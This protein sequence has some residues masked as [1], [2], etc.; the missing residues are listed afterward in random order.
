MLTI[1]E[2]NREFFEKS[3]KW[4]ANPEIKK[5]TLSSDI[6]DVNREKW[7]LSLKDEDDYLIWGLKYND[8]P[9]GTFGIKNIEWNKGIGEYW[10]YIGEKD[11]IGKGYGKEMVSFMFSNAKSLHLNKLYLKVADYNER[12]IRLYIKCGF[13]EVDRLQR[14]D[15]QIIIMEKE[16]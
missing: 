9:I 1:T 16:I 3:K 6:D 15:Y 10:G 7:F 5:L 2:F 4:L 8:M 13:N 14:D 12:A 11:Y